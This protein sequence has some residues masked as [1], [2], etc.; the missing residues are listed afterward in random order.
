MTRVGDTAPRED[1]DRADIAGLVQTFFA[2][3]TSGP[4]VTARLGALRELFLPGAV[5]VR[6]GGDAPTV[7]DVDGFIGPRLALLTDG[8]VTDFAERA[9]SGRTELWGDVAAWFGDYRKAWTENGARCT[10]RGAKT[11]QFVRT[12]A[13][14]RISAAAWDDERPAPAPGAPTG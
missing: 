9:T 5:V 7:Y 4:D 10:G 2:A 6:A 1:D 12:P 3:F 11:L 14:W 13:G 8:R